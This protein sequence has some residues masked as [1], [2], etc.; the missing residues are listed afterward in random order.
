MEAAGGSMA[1]VVKTTVFLADMN[2]FA[3]MNAVYV[4][5]E[6]LVSA[7]GKAASTT[8]VGDFIAAA[9]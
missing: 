8:E 1:D 4:V 7:G 9:V 2:D 5:T 3:A 6:D